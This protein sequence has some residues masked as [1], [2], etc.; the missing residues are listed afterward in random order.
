MNGLPENEKAVAHTDKDLEDLIPGYLECR[1]RDVY[2]M[3]AAL[4]EGAGRATGQDDTISF[5]EAR[6]L[7]EVAQLQLF[8]QIEP[9]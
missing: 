1:R 5:S 9:Y 2:A 7:T 8:F 4:R 3:S 6:S